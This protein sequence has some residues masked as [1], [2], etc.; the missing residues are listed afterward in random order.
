[1]CHAGLGS[2]SGGALGRELPS[3]HPPAFFSSGLPPG[4]GHSRHR[5]THP[6]A[7]WEAGRRLL[8][9]AVPGGPCS[10]SK[11][12]SGPDLAPAPSDRGVAGGATSLPVISSPRAPSGPVFPSYGLQHPPPGV[13]HVT[14]GGQKGT[15]QAGSG[16]EAGSGP[17][18]GGRPWQ[19]E[20]PP[21]QNQA[22]PV[23]RDEL[24]RPKV[25]QSRPQPMRG[26]GQEPGSW[27][28]KET[29]DLRPAQG[30][31]GVGGLRGHLPQQTL[32]QH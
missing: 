13:W 32:T 24:E 25:E 14:E 10:Q 8:A 4:L 5:Y 11:E 6:G 12:R 18:A 22:G 30:E 20:E 9:G 23:G 19:G 29:L 21:E 3:H 28:G 31:A 1:M 7:G 16:A 15:R 27:P 17:A 26:Q 2:E